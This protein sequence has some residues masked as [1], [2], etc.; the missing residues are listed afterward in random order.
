MPAE[1]KD[2]GH[3]PGRPHGAANIHLLA[4]GFAIIK[5]SGFDSRPGRKNT[6]T[7]RIW[8]H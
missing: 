8:K 6:P 2:G 7:T 4:I 5:S 3:C 1:L